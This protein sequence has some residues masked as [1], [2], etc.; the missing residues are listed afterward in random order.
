MNPEEPWRLQRAAFPLLI[1]LLSAV[2]ASAQA[3]RPLPKEDEQL[4]NE[5]QAV[6]HT[7][8]QNDGYV[9]PGDL[10]IIGTNLRFTFF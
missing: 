7:M 9:R 4:W 10:N 8:R 2:P 5:V 1:V 3:E 6:I